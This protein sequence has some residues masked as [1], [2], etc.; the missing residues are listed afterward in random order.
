MKNTFINRNIR[1][2]KTKLDDSSFINKMM[3][4]FGKNDAFN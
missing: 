1:N 3:N 2:L 4:C